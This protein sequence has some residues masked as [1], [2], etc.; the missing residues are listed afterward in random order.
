MTVLLSF[1]NV[2]IKADFKIQTN[3]CHR[4]QLI[5]YL[6]Y[7][8]HYYG[9]DFYALKPGRKAQMKYFKVAM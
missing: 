3:G 4:E 2:Y 9:S 7:L 5:Y 1:Y 8:Y 6:E